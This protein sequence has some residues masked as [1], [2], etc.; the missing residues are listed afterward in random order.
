MSDSDWDESSEEYFF[1]INNAQESVIEKPL[2]AREKFIRRIQNLQFKPE[3][4]SEDE[5]E[6]PSKSASD[7]LKEY[8]RTCPY[9][10]NKGWATTNCSCGS[11]FQVWVENKIMDEKVEPYQM[12]WS[13][14]TMALSPETREITETESV[15]S[16]SS[17]V[18]CDDCGEFHSST[19]EGWSEIE[20]PV[21]D[22]IVDE[23]DEDRVNSLKTS[24]KSVV[25]NYN[26]L[27]TERECLITQLQQCEERLE[28]VQEKKACLEREISS[29]STITGELLADLDD[30]SQAIQILLNT[31]EYYDI[32]DLIGQYASNGETPSDIKK[33]I[34]IDAKLLKKQIFMDGADMEPL[35]KNADGL[36]RLHDSYITDSYKI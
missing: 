12:S 8:E 15:S 29:L 34:V 13:Q 35:P 18:E 23:I 33:K 22:T 11:E 6:K 2:N 9:C 36:P 20:W 21:I 28:H 5:I 19:E 25:T 10:G 26:A 31:G 7:L 24:L 14:L 4:L 1:P 17:E 30:F 3:I 27:V 16:D 32:N